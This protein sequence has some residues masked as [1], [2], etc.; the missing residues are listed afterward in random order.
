MEMSFSVLRHLRNY[1]TGGL[2]SALIGVASFP[3]LTRSLS[4]EDYGIVGLILSTLTLFVAVGKCGV[5]HS[6][7]RFYAEVKNRN[8]KFT[9]S[10]FYSTTIALAFVLSIVCMVVWLV[11]GFWLVPAISDSEDITKYF[12]LGTLYI[13]L[14]ILSSNPA[15]VLSAQLKSG[16]VM[17]SVVI[18]RVVYISMILIYLATKTISVETVV[19]SFIVAEMISLIYLLHHYLPGKVHSFKGIG[20]SF[21]TT[22][23]WFGFPLMALES[24]GLMMRLSDRY[25]IQYLLDENALGQYAASHN[26]SG[27]VEIIVTSAVISA[28]KPIYNEIWE[29]KGKKATQSFLSRSFHIYL[30]VGIPFV[31]MFSLTAP[32]VVNILASTKYQPGTVIIPWITAGILIEGSVLFLAAG[33][34]IK[35][36]TSKLVRWGF[37]A[38]LANIILNFIFIPRFG[39]LGAAVVTLFTYAIYSIG[40]MWSAFKLLSFDVAVRNPVVMVVASLLTWW[41]VS[42]I[43]VPGDFLAVLIKG[44]ISVVVLAVLAL[45]IDPKLRMVLVEFL[46]RFSP[47]LGSV[48]ISLGSQLQ[49]LLGRSSQ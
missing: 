14:R 7:I 36:Q 6:I 48:G 4:V 34:D 37:I 21:A 9:E 42:R 33:I 46:Q 11:A 30:M 45:C 24:L 23:L 43:P 26:F 47:R 38:L 31:A 2:V 27:Y 12:L 35:K 39:I 49:G 44:T 8:S 40:I 25:I 41:L 1:A 15:N 29:T 20:V 10:E 18:R 5:Q 28:I 17:R 19:L 16:I 13:F 22:L 32:H 3:I